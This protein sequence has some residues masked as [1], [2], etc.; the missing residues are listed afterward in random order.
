MTVFSYAQLEGLWI[1]AGGP[2][3]VAPIAAAIAEAESRGN[4]TA[5][6]AK[7]SNGRGGTQVSAG[8]WQISNGT[9]T[10]VPNWSDPAVNAKDA[11]A[12]Y[13]AGWHGVKP[14]FGAWGTFTSGAYKGFL[15]GKTAPD[16]NVPSASGAGGGGAGGS[17]G[18]GITLDAAVKA[19]NPDCLWSVGWA[20]ISGTANVGKGANWIQAALGALGGQGS[21]VV[22]GSIAGAQNAG[23][24]GAFKACIISKSQARALIGAGLMLAGALVMLAGVAVV[25]IA[26]GMRALGPAGKAAEGVGGALMLVPGAEGAGAMIAGAGRGAR[27][28]ARAGRQRQARQASEERDMQRR[29]GEPRENPD[30]EVRGGTVR[31]S[32]EQRAARRRREQ[33][34]ARAAARRS[35]GQGRPASREEAGF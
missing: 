15:S 8:L 16:M 29:L 30:L 18:G 19:L 22:G 11:V 35:A 21:G 12:K 1:N 2:K 27:N 14:S 32:D 34:A 28:P 6:N 20:G 7:D 10:P 24:I 9:M 26:A 23:N 3:A 33:G 31:E 4:S 17:G 5:Y 13:N 25:G